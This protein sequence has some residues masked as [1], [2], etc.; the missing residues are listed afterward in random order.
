[1]IVKKITPKKVINSS[2]VKY[3]EKPVKPEPITDPIIPKKK[4]LIDSGTK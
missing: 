1:M 3:E 4:Y 2:L